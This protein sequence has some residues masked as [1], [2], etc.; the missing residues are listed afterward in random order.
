ML[1]Y[2]FQLIYKKGDKMQADY[3]PR[4]VV[5]AIGL[6]NREMEE[7]QDQDELIWMFLISQELPSY[8]TF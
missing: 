8:P 1:D 4:N 6:S 3:L 7:F 5:S 2:N